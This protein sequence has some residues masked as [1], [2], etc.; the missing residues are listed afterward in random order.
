VLGG[1]SEKIAKGRRKVKV[2]SAGTNLGE[3]VLAPGLFQ[4]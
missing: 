4:K 1:K 2:E 3:M